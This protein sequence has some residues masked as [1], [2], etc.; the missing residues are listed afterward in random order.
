VVSYGSNIIGANAM[1]SGFKS[2]R[3]EGLFGEEGLTTRLYRKLGAHAREESDDRWVLDIEVVPVN[4]RETHPDVRGI[5]HVRI[6]SPERDDHSDSVGLTMVPSL[7][8]VAGAD[9][10]RR[11]RR[12]SSVEA[13]VQF[14]EDPPRAFF[15]SEGGMFEQ[16][17]LTDDSELVGDL[18]TSLR[19]IDDAADKGRTRYI[20]PQA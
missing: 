2:E 6:V 7:G 9:L 12:G 15:P 17:E 13:I 4:E 11:D 14:D 5:G 1:A 10:L 16:V 19:F 18:E 8:R 20:P 3:L